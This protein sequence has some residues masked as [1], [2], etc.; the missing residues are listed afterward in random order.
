MGKKNEK[1]NSNN[2]PFNMVET[3]LDPRVHTW[4]SSTLSK[5]ATSL[6]LVCC[7]ICKTST[8]IK[9]SHASFTR[10]L[11]FINILYQKYSIYSILP[12][13]MF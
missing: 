13:V 3:G 6:V 9:E 1:D 4:Q 8:I 12:S 2:V 7:F 11:Y 10:K 5:Q